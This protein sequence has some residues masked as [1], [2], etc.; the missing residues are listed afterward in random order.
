MSSAGRVIAV[1]VALATAAITGYVAGRPDLWAFA[2]SAK[3]AGAPTAPALPSGDVIYY[4][5]P[6]GKPVY[7]LTPK[8]TPDGRNFL[9]VR[10]SEDVTFETAQEESTAPIS[11]KIKFYR[12]PMG[13]PDTSPAPKKDSMGMSYIPV[14]AGD[15]G[16]DGVIRLS[17]GKLQRTGVKSSPATSRVISAAIKAPG[18]IQLDERR[19]TVISMRAETWIEKVEDVTTGA[20]VR[21]GQPLMR[22]YSPALTAAAADYL[23][24]LNGSVSALSPN[25]GARQ[26][27]SNLDAP[28]TLIALIEKSRAAPLAVTWAAPRDGIVIERTAIEGMRAE[29]GAVLFRIADTAVVWGQVD[30]AERDLGNVAVGQSA[31]VRARSYP[32]RTFAGKITVIYP[33]INRETRTARARVEL[34][35]ADGALL[36][37]MFVDA[38]IG[39]GEAQPVLAVPDSA[40]I[41]TGTRQ[42][43]FVDKG[44]GKLE[45]RDV[46]LGAR[47]GGYV[48]IREGLKEGE[49]VVESANFLI[50]AES[51]LKAALKGFGAATEAPR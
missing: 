44:E 38:E 50:D 8:A 36:P 15:D 5:D 42:A 16:D 35:N 39:I 51:N 11:R 19:I 6:E 4:R 27:L 46:K 2:F 30:I 24:V 22:V 49:S 28:E 37:E 23:S 3:M 12:N 13:L 41:D 48:E 7:S 33:Q 20:F 32:G 29:P 26:R 40:V 18:S 1:G 45:P 25:R 21:K 10:T 17:P 31:T 9:A 43:L 47:G 14:Y 34:S